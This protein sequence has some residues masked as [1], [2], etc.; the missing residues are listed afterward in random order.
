MTLE[1][2]RLDP[3]ADRLLYEQM[4][5]WLHASPLWRQDTET[6]FGTLDL[7]EYMAATHDSTRIDVGV[8]EDGRLIADVIFTM[9][10]KGVFEV[11]LEAARG[12][13]IT[14]IVT[15]GRLIRDQIFAQ[16]AQVVY[17]WVPR[18]NLAVIRILQAIG[19]SHTYV[20]MLRTT[21][22]GRVTEWAKLNIEVGYGQQEA[23]NQT[24]T[25]SDL[26]RHQSV[27]LDDAA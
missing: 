13:D 20:S 16:G 15:A 19:F 10:A 27:R 18:R 5:L 4:F 24:V 21:P 2:R 11:H 12:A 6:V 17:A 22:G 23:G 1:I 7:T 14:A 3:N 26:Q 8:F 9:R 25:E